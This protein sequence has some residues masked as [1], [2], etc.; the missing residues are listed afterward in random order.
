M[1]LLDNQT[2]RRMQ[3]AL[4]IAARVLLLLPRFLM[5]VLLAVPFVSRAAVTTPGD[6]AKGKLL[7]E[8]RCT[9]CH[10]LDLEKEGPRL[11]GVYGR[12]SGA[13]PGFDYSSQLKA[14]HLTWDETLLDRWL[15][16]TDS[17][18]PG[19]GMDFR[20]PKADER[21]DIIAYLRSLSAK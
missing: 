10:S 21:A 16:D 18:V 20:V 9:G 14:A 6:A 4:A 11:R 8:K 13:I 17:V 2:G 3:T 1:R 7:F 19:N 5:L 12:A 15:T